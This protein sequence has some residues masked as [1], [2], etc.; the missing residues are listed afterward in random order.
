MP[1][2]LSCRPCWPIRW[3]GPDARGRHSLVGIAEGVPQI[4]SLL[5]LSPS[6]A[7]HRKG[8]APVSVCSAQRSARVSQPLSAHVASAHLTK[9]PSRTPSTAGPPVVINEDTAPDVA[10]RGRLEVFEVSRARSRRFFGGLVQVDRDWMTGELKGVVDLA[11]SRKAEGANPGQ[12]LR[13]PL[14]APIIITS[15]S[16]SSSAQ[17]E[18]NPDLPPDPPPFSPF[19]SFP[20]PFERLSPPHADGSQS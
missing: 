1:D 17:V 13:G 14:G 12:A 15:A 5:R 8:S 6:V 18:P 16:L 3:E 19:L 9:I 10:A 11:G 20:M 7:V 2:V 4:M